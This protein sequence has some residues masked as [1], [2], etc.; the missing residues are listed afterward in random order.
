MDTPTT[1]SAQGSVQARPDMD[2]GE[3]RQPPAHPR[4]FGFAEIAFL[5]GVP[6]AWAVSSSSTRPAKARTSIRSSRTR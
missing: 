6:L 4:P 3:G 1:Q 2:I 5:I